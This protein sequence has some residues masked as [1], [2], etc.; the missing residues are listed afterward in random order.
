MQVL[1]DFMMLLKLKFHKT[2][3]KSHNKLKVEGINWR[4]GKGEKK[5]MVDSIGRITSWIMIVKA[6]L[7]NVNR[8]SGIAYHRQK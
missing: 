4:K 2:Q 6:M 3:V 8:E 5:K 1:F 7:V